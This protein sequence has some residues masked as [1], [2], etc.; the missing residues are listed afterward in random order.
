MASNDFDTLEGQI[1]VSSRPATLCYGK[2]W[3]F[4]NTLISIL[5][6]TFPVNR[7]NRFVVFGHETP[8]SDETNMMWAR[9][10]TSGN[11]TGWFAFVKGQWQ[12][13]YS[14]APKEIRWFYGDSN[15]PALGWLPLLSTANGVSQAIVDK[16]LA[17]YV[18]IV[19]GQYSYYAARYIGY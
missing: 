3:D 1:V 12:R 19:P 14:P 2:P 7:N 13:F 8:G 5:K 6:V 4:I 16:L 11:P 10:D 9:F 18:E 15:S 17:Q